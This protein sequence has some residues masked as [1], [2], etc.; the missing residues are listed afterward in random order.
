VQI[1]ANGIQREYQLSGKQ[2]AP[3]VMM[4][5]ALGTSLAMWEYQLEA[6]DPHFQVLRYDTRGHGGSD[7]P[8][9]AYTLDQLG[10]DAISLLDVLGITKV[11]WVGISMG[12]MIGQGLALNHPDR[13]ISLSLCD[14]TAFIPQEAQPLWQER[15]ETAQAKGLSALVESTLGRWFTPSYLTQGTHQ[16][17]RIRQQFLATPVSG[18]IGCSEAIR[19]L[20]YLDRLQ[21]ITTPTLIVVGENDQGT[22]VAASEAIS[23]RIAGSRLVVLSSAAH[24]SNIQQSEV[25]NRVLLEFLKEFDLQP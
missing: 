6:L 1:Y 11:H 14:T 21:E 17:D 19:R 3:V 25:F 4:S 13:I 10:T 20:N 18:Y 9:G 23:K 2:G 16:G 8:A 22:P 7:A 5:H 12:G 15:I 24:L